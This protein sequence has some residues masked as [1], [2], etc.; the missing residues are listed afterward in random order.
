MTHNG[1]MHSSIDS[2]DLPIQFS[3]ELP[4]QTKRQ[5]FHATLTGVKWTFDPVDYAMDVTFSW[6][7]NNCIATEINS[8]RDLITWGTELVFKGHYGESLKVATV[9]FDNIS[10]SPGVM[11]DASGSFIV[12]E[13]T[14]M[15]GELRCGFQGAIS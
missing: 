14:T 3:Y 6:Q 4:M 8:L 11:F 1:L 9:A 7:C 10:C 5:S 13:V 12:L 15:P 2:T